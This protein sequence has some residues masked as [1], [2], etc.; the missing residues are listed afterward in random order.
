MSRAAVLVTSCLAV[1]LDVKH[2][3]H[4]HGPDTARVVVGADGVS[5]A[6]V[7]VTDTPSQVHEA[8]D[9]NKSLM[10]AIHERSLVEEVDAE[11]DALQHALKGKLLDSAKNLGETL[12]IGADQCKP[13][14][15]Q[16]C[17]GAVK[18][19][20]NLTPDK[21][22]IAGVEGVGAVTNAVTDATALASADVSKQISKVN[23]RAGAAHFSFCCD[24]GTPC[25]CS[26]PA[27]PQSRSGGVGAR[28]DLKCKDGS[29]AVGSGA[30]DKPAIIELCLGFDLCESK[31]G[32]DVTDAFSE[33]IVKE[34]HV[35]AAELDKIKASG[36]C[37]NFEQRVC[38]KKP[39]AK[40]CK[41]LDMSALQKEKA[42]C[43]G[44]A[45][46]AF[47]VGW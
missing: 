28:P 5:S 30:D 46:G 4:L 36:K 37:E 22:G 21:C 3:E 7:G 13:A 47:F 25:D 9:G 24:L 43:I 32:V 35:S 42:A 8:S 16:V 10:A 41:G 18:C 11:T 15:Y 33:A 14:S 26:K 34:G 31:Q 19:H 38:E 45:L 1:T 6:R 39:N 40:L 23:N 17:C 44:V 20:C 12:G 2:S 29:E 27:P